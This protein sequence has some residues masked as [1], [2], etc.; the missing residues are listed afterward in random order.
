MGCHHRHRLLGVTNPRLSGLSPISA[1]SVNAHAETMPLELAEPNN[2][3]NTTEA[4]EMLCFHPVTARLKAAAGE[5]PGCQTDNLWDP[6]N[7][8]KSPQ[9]IASFEKLFYSRKEAA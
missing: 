4:A 3:M 5:I 8:S 2:I 7:N 1:L 9:T 6:M